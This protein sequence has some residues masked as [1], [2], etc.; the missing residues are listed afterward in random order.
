MS[1]ATTRLNDCPK[2]VSGPHP[3]APAAESA[4]LPRGI[5]FRVEAIRH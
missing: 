5:P 4:D 2:V 3:L 1:A